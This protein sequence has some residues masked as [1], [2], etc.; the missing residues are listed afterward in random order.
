[1]RAGGHEVGCAES[2]GPAAGIAVD[3]PTGP[4]VGATH[5]AGRRRNRRPADVGGFWCW[6]RSVH[7]RCGRGCAPHRIRRPRRIPA[8]GP[9]RLP[10]LHRTG[11]RAHHDRGGS[12]VRPPARSG[13]NPSDEPR[14]RPVKRLDDEVVESGLG[15]G[16]GALVEGLEQ[17]QSAVVSEEDL[18]RVGIE[19]EH[20]DWAPSSAALPTIQSRRAW[21]PRCT[22]SKV[23]VVTMRR[24]PLGKWGR[25]W[26]TF[27]ASKGRGAVSGGRCQGAG[28]QV[29]CRG[30][31]R[32]DGPCGTR[33]ERV[34]DLN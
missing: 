30:K 14:E 21:C 13:R 1:M 31:L 32:D 27:T 4:R 8:A 9:H 18:P 25:P 23:P 29:E 6:R 7:P 33:R 10:G 26:W 3:D 34:E 16:G 22:P 19:G 24:T 2:E 12:P 20:H 15:E 17:L 28:T 11:G 5:P